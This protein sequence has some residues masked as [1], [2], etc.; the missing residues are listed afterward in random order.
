MVHAHRLCIVLFHP[1][2]IYVAASKVELR[3]CVSTLGSQLV[4]SCRLNQ[5]LFNP[6]TTRETTRKITSCMHGVPPRFSVPDQL[7]Q[8]T[9]MLLVRHPHWSATLWALSAMRRRH[10]LWPALAADTLTACSA[11]PMHRTGHNRILFLLQ[12]DQ[13]R[14]DWVGIRTLLPLCGDRRRCCCCPSPL[15][16][17]GS[18]TPS[19]T[20]AGHRRIGTML[21][22]QRRLLLGLQFGTFP[23]VVPSLPMLPLAHLVAIIHLGA[24]VAHLERSRRVACPAQLPFFLRTWFSVGA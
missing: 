11:H 10:Q 21:P 14:V 22:Q 1:F 16:R 5:I 17:R 12:T 6:F 4:Q 3:P 7:L 9:H 13:A 18:R 19:S 23:L 8:P 2:T 20:L 15:T 24:A